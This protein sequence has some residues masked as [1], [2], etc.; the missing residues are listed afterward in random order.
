MFAK[1]LLLVI[2][3]CSNS[4][5]FDGSVIPVVP[6]TPEPIRITLDDLP[7]PFSTTSATKPAIVVGVPEN[8]TLMVPDPKFRVSIFWDGLSGPRNMIFTPTGEI[9]V[10][11]SHGN[12]ITILSGNQSSTFADQTNGISEAFGMAF[13]NVTS[14]TI[15]NSLI[16]KF[17]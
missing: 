9:L 1:T 8:A 16:R 2:L 6:F 13:A 7:A 17:S 11:E 10:T 3:A 4:L 14:Y 12:R 15:L 5:A